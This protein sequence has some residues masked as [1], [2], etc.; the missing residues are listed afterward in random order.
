M[1]GTQ[2]QRKEAARDQTHPKGF[3]VRLPHH[4]RTHCGE[5]LANKADF[6]SHTA[7]SSSASVVE[8]AMEKA[9]RSL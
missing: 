2:P 6:D 5:G 3:P 9:G 1:I 4:I 7:A 8:I